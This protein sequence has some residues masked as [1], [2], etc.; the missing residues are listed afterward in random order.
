M[1][2]IV[3]KVVCVLGLTASICM[4]QIVYANSDGIS[5]AKEKAEVMEEEKQRVEESIA[6]LQ[7][8]K[9]DS[10]A[11]VTQLDQTLNSYSTEL[12][13]LNTDIIAKQGE[14]ELAQTN[15]TEA[16]RIEEDQFQQMKIRIKYMYEQGELS[17]LDDL[18]EADSLADLFN[19]AEYFTKISEY[20]R[21][22]LTE[23]GEIKSGI[24]SIKLTLEA[25]KTQL[26]LLQEET[27]LKKASVE[28]LIAEKTAELAAFDEKILAAENQISTIEQDIKAQEDEVKRLEEEIRRQEE[29]AR[30]KAEEEGK[31]YDVVS[32]GDI[33]FK[34]PVPASSRITSKFGNRVS[35]TEGASSNHKGIDIGAPT[36][37]DIIA[38]ASGTV[39]I[40]QYSSSA[41]N[42]VMLNHGGGIYTVYMHCS[43]LLVSV[44][45]SV[46]E[47]Q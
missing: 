24:E 44:G 26:V 23:Y 4:S 28:T 8:L 42:Y 10:A 41:G 11:Y 40:S 39:V 3:C 45:E 29:E 35:P 33:S 31:T 21:N 1:R 15:L 5:E 14:I 6:E 19:Q 12:T 34:W 9:G 46:S 18:M 16:E 13:Q 2:G 32:L 17:A 25:E 22:K 47:G 20:D 43:Q 7:R 38:S 37:T 30:K 36:G 27:T